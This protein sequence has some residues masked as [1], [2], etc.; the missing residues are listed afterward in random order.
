VASVRPQQLA[1]RAKQKTQ[2]GATTRNPRKRSFALPV[3]TGKRM[4]R[5]RT[6]SSLLWQPPTL[7]PL[8]C[9][10]VT[11]NGHTPSARARH[12]SRGRLESQFL[13]ARDSARQTALGASRGTLARQAPRLQR[14]VIHHEAVRYPGSRVFVGAVNRQLLASVQLLLTT[15]H[16]APRRA[17]VRCHSGG[18]NLPHPLRFRLAGVT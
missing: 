16:S 11:P 12:N 14:R 3:P 15:R 1:A 13:K 10:M 5:S 9:Q 2:A 18:V 6:R 4:L 8:Q 7:R 17:G